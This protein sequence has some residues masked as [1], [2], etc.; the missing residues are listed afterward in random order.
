MRK[1]WRA[2]FGRVQASVLEY[3]LPHQDH[4][5]RKDE[6]SDDLQR[7][8]GALPAEGHGQA[9]KMKK[10]ARATS[11]R[12]TVEIATTGKRRRRTTRAKAGAETDGLSV[13]CTGSGRMSGMIF[14]FR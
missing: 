5:H 4:P 9:V 3:E 14:P 8:F 6:K 12:S 10:S 1:L 2:I 7:I 11:A 13:S